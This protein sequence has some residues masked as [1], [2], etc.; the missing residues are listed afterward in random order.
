MDLVDERLF[1]ELMTQIKG[2]R[3]VQ[4]I[5]REGVII[6]SLLAQDI[7]GLDLSTLTNM[8]LSSL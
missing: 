1:R 7:T 3:A 4:L 6:H 8:F 5:T 2:T